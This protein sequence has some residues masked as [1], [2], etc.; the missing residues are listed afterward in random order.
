MQH[1]TCTRPETHTVCYETCGICHTCGILIIKII[2]TT[3]IITISVVYNVWEEEGVAFNMGMGKPVVFPKRIAQVQVWWWN[4]AHHDTPCTHTVVLQV[5][6]GKLQQGDL[7]FSLIFPFF[8]S[9]FS[10]NSGCHTVMEPY[11]ARS[12]ACIFLLTI[13]SL[14]SYTPICYELYCQRVVGR[15]ECRSI[16]TEG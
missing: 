14:L 13:N 12:A 8:T 10:V 5:W 6:T 16:S 4:S 15:A 9:V 11:M 7:N 2:K 3:T 1:C